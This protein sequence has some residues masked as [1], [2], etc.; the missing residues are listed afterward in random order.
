MVLLQTEKRFATAAFY[1]K[2]ICL[3]NDSFL[4]NRF[5]ISGDKNQP[6]PLS[7]TESERIFQL[8]SHIKLFIH[9]KTATI[10][11]LDAGLHSEAIRHFSKIVDGRR[12][13]SQG[14]LA[15]CYVHRAC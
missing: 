10:S 1:R 15:D 12:G 2:S 14:I 6:Q 9:R 11:A 3:S 4:F 8:L 5:P 7:K 13:A